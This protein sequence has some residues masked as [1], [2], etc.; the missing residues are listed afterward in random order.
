[1]SAKVAVL[2]KLMNCPTAT[3]TVLSSDYIAARH[4]EPWLNGLQRVE[5]TIGVRV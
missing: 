2:K 4:P 1:M 3:G 5:Y